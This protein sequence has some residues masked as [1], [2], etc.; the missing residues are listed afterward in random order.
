MLNSDMVEGKTGLIKVEDIAASILEGFLHYLYSG[1][2]PEFSVATAKEF[3]EARDKYAVEELKM[4]CSEFLTKNLSEDNAFDL[5]LFA[6]QHSDELFRNDIISYIVKKKNP[7]RYTQ[8]S[9]F[10]KSHP[11]LAVEVQNLYIEKHCPE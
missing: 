7:R 6:D 5:L 11:N 10:C 9:N 8:W 2:F 4:A 1:T 3:Y